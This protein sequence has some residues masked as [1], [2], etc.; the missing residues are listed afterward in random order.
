[1]A[2]RSGVAVCCLMPVVLVALAAV[3]SY[4]FARHETMYTRTNMS[5]LAVFLLIMYC[6][7]IIR[8]LF[9]PRNRTVIMDLDAASRRLGGK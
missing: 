5:C 2:F 8:M 4:D 6:Q 9:A 3:H 7:N 1:M